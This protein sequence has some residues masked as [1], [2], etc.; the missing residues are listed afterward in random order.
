M[1]R[2]IARAMPGAHLIY[3][4]DTARMP[5]GNRPPSEITRFAR[6]IM[7]FLLDQGVDAV[8][9]ACNTTSA[10]ALPTL[11]GQFD[12]PVVGMIECGAAAAVEASRSGRIG[13]IA[14]ANTVRSSAYAGAIASLR[15]GAYVVQHACP[16]LVPLIER[17]EVSGEAV[18]SVLR[19]YMR[20]LLAV[21]IDTIVYGC[22]HYPFLDAE[23]RVLAGPGV[24]LVDPAFRVALA[25]RSALLAHDPD[26]A[27]AAGTP[28]AAGTLGTPGALG[29]A[30]ALR[31]ITSGDPE[32]FARLAQSLMGWESCSVQQVSVDS[33]G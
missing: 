33:L 1:A 16:L 13:V 23:A 26:L 30:G 27:G 2:T 9:V 18:R 15:P 12:V 28:D 14:T 24:K 31:L 7:H 32:A 3:Y 4:G 21:G 19:D 17:G 6:E 10:L 25:V 22:T 5:Y 20:P 29:K 8:A 11:R